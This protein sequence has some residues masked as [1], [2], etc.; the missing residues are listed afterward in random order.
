VEL[1]GGLLNVESNVGSGTIVTVRLP[2][3]RVLR[4]NVR[5]AVVGGQ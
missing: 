4:G 5:L 1:H 2:R 3:D